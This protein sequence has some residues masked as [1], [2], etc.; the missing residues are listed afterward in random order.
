MIPTSS[1]RGPQQ[2][3]DSYNRSSNSTEADRRQFRYVACF[4]KKPNFA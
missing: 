1:R 3:H 4:A 2:R